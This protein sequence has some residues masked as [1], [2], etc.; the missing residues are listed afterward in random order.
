MSEDCRIKLCARDRGVDHCYECA[1]YPCARLVAFRNDECAHHSVV[2]KNQEA[3]REQGVGRWLEAQQ[4]RWSCPT[5]GRAS[6]WYD[7]ACQGC[8]GALYNCEDEE[9]DLPRG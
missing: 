9:A 3:K 5:C 8:G 7:K 2:L 1:G 4:A 6:S